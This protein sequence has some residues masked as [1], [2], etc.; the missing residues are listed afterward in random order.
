MHEWRELFFLQRAVYQLLVDQLGYLYLHTHVQAFYMYDL[1]SW[2]DWFQRKEFFLSKDKPI[3]QYKMYNAGLSLEY[4]S[5]IFKKIQRNPPNRTNTLCT[6]KY[7]SGNDFLSLPKAVNPGFMT[8]CFQDSCLGED[9]Q[10][11]SHRTL[12]CSDS[13][14]SAGFIFRQKLIPQLI[15]N[16]LSTSSDH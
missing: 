6:Y 15:R 5:K 14:W 11:I 2:V 10:V 1:F 16:T 12:L 13:L 9:G 7:S 4:K 3:Y 8:Q